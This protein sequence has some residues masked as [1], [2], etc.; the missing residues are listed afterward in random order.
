MRDITGGKI[1]TYF[2]RLKHDAKMLIDER[3]DM[4][5]NA[6]VKGL[7]KGGIKSTLQNLRENLFSEKFGP[8][9]VENIK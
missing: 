7:K 2:Q 4:L 9:V 5:P 3:K 6:Y 1:K 8:T